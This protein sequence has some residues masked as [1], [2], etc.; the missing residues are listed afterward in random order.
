MTDSWLEF[1]LARLAESGPVAL[2]WE[3][4]LRR[5]RC[6]L[7]GVASEARTRAVAA[8]EVVYLADCVRRDLAK[9]GRDREPSGGLSMVADI[10]RAHAEM[11]AHGAVWARVRRPP[12][13][14]V[15]TLRPGKRPLARRGVAPV[16][17]GSE[18]RPT[19]A[20][21]W[22]RRASSLPR[23]RARPLGS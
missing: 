3:P 14:I 5:W 1:A 9:V 6:V 2:T 19:H 23:A 13:R 18:P 7:E 8:V 10:E 16:A 20:A 17:S 15:V 22:A 12:G 21:S 11:A 4:Q